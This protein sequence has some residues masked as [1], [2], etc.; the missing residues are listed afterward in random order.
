[1]SWLQ[2]PKPDIDIESPPR[3]DSAIDAK[4]EELSPP[5]CTGIRWP[6]V[7][8]ERAKSTASP[9][10]RSSSRTEKTASLYSWVYQLCMR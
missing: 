4:V 1:M 7:V 2:K 5:Q 3:S 10:P 9:A 6:P 8:A